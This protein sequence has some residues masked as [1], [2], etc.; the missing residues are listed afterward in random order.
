MYS[1]QKPT[2]TQYR[3]CW[4][5]A[6]E[7]N[8]PHGHAAGLE[9]H[10]NSSPSGGSNRSARSR[11][12]SLTPS[13]Q[14]VSAVFWFIKL[15]FDKKHHNQLL[16][17]TCVHP[18]EPIFKRYKWPLERHWIGVMWKRADFS[19]ESPTDV[20]PIKKT[21]KVIPSGSCNKPIFWKRI[22]F[23]PSKFILPN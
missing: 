10:N 4:F 12:S 20:L 16:L 7:L 2:S 6:W 14:S 23:F 19:L 17:Y 8:H 22:L 13:G 1:L 21:E 9:P 3:S 5:H 18:E 11:L 15:Q